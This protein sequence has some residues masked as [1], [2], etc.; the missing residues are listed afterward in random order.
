[1]VRT[2]IAPSPTGKD[3]HVGSVSTAL[4][5][6]AWAKKNDG[7]FIIRIEDTDQ[8]RLVPGGEKRMLETLEAIGLHADESPLVGG[9]YAPYRQSERLAVYK[10]HAEELVQKRKAYYCICKPERLDEMRKKQQAVK[11]IPKYDRYCYFH[12]E[13]I[14]NKIVKGEKYVIRLFI[15][16][17][18]IIFNDLIRGQI[19]VEGSNLDDQIILKSDGYPTYHLGVVVDDYLMKITHVIRGEEWLPSTPKH[20]VLYEAFGWSLPL[21]AHV[22]L[23]RN[24]DKS[25]LSKR[26][27]PV[28]TSEYLEKGIL[29]EALLNYL[30][31]MG[32]SH[33]EGKEIFSLE[34]YVK[35]FDI[36]DVQKTAPVFDPVKLEWMNGEYLRKLKVQSLKLKVLGFIGKNYPEGIVEKTIPLVQERMKKLADY[37]PLC[38][39]F[40]QAP[41]TWQV[42]LSGKKDFFNRVVGVLEKVNTWKATA[43]GEAMQKLAKELNIKNSQFF[44]DLRVAITGKRISPPLNESME[45]LRK[46]E[47][48][49]R[50]KKL[51]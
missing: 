26:R 25:K 2:R 8:T 36:K 5:N 40:F 49:E 10:K 9:P 24:P 16:N 28:W 22:S 29:P 6:Y 14:K 31:L 44:M 27:N 45:I 19:E 18:K 41:A 30:S 1:M 15:P 20:I 11:Q 38:E 3:V 43:I 48:L 35:I 4:M 13:E 47:C 23:L 50:V 32:W 17:K 34:E 21:F 51:T 12:Q 33:P 39:F 46:E 37:L 7:Q 42:D